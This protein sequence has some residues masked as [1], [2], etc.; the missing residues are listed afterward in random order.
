MLIA[1]MQ[2]P[3]SAVHCEAS[4]L[5]HRMGELTVKTSAGAMVSI[6]QQSHEFWFGAAISNRIFENE[7]SQKD[8][9]KYKQVFL[10][11]F[12]SAVTENA[13]KWKVMQPTQEAPDYA[14]VD[15]ILEWTDANGIPLRGHN[16]FWGVHKFVQE[17]VKDL[18][19]EQLHATLEA[20]AKDIGSR[21][22]G[23][24][25]QY[26]LNNEM[27]HKNY[28][29]EQLGEG[30]TLEMANWVKEED[31]DAKLYL[32]DYD[33]L[34]GNRLDDYMQH[35]RD[36]LGMGVPIAGIGV[37][38]HLHTET[39][40]PAEL[41]HALDELAQFGLPIVITEFNMPGQ[42]SKYYQE[43]GQ[44]AATPET[45]KQFAKELADY[46]RICFAHPAVTGI[47]MWGFWERANWIPESSMFDANW[48]PTP[49]ADAYRNLVFG[50]WWTNTTVKADAAG[51]VTIPA[52]YGEYIIRANGKE[53]RVS[54]SSDKG[55][56]LVM[57]N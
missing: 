3:A 54:L 10:E 45:R 16:I 7:Y 17:W 18:D 20:R 51:N 56:K 47:L 42:H 12:N 26:D 32:N 9:A 4:N 35:V 24:F 52:F 5:D 40:D 39:F 55:K 41:K 6:E 31:S 48:N 28:Y 44:H 43:R 8:I 30:I 50:E 38:G 2:F 19:K 21:Y 53:K 13:L 46:Y 33:I 27:I 57:M 15:A 37:Q 11:N 29:A 22:K 23:R 1:G 36:L 34:T 49:L 14:V 25:A